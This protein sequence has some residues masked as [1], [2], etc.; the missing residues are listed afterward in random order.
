MMKRKKLRG[1][2]IPTICLILICTILFSSY[3]MYEILSYEAP[4]KDN[5][6]E[7]VIN[8]NYKENDEMVNATTSS[9]SIIRPYVLDSVTATIPFYNREG[10]EEE[11]T[12][13]LI[14]YEGIY[15]PNTGVLY[16]ANEVFDCVAVLDGVVKNVKEDSIMGNIVEIEHTNS[17]TTIYQNLG[18]V[19]VTIGASVKQGDIIA[20][21]GNNTLTSD[22]S[23][24]LHF[25]VF[26]KGELINPEE[27][28]LYDYEEVINE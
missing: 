7:P 10:T 9:K 8:G 18:E 13:A 22:N 14:Y 28:Y 20:L 3:K 25:E 17:L 26:Y 1:Y 23:N 15:M 19:K 4:V 11:Q 5:D 12:A 21:S 24:A 16:T 27:F 6:N 2:V